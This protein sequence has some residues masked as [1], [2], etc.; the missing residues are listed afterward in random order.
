MESK[1]VCLQLVDAHQNLLNHGVVQLF[2]QPHPVRRLCDVAASDADSG[3]ASLSLHV[4]AG[5]NSLTSL[6]SVHQFALTSTYALPP[7]RPSSGVAD[8]VRGRETVCDRLTAHDMQMIG[9]LIVELFLSSSCWSLSRDD[10]GDAGLGTSLLGRYSL[11]RSLLSQSQHQLHW[12]VTSSRLFA[13]FV[14]VIWSTR[15]NR[16]SKAGL[17]VHPSHSYCTS[18]CLPSTKSFLD[19]N[20]ICCVGRDW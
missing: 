2:T 17:D 13:K 11:I 5:L 20:M 4:D 7:Q 18:I 3:S 9:C 14:I 16:P 15:P 6:E 10:C 19:L 8:S 1:N 12:Y